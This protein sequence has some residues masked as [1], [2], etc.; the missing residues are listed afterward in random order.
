MRHI[1]LLLACDNISTNEL[2]LFAASAERHNVG[3]YQPRPG[4]TI[5]RDASA[6]R[7]ARA[8]CLD[9][10]RAAPRRRDLG[11]LGIGPFRHP[12]EQQSSGAAE[13]CTGVVDF[14]HFLDATL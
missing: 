6:D 1:Y 8:H 11:R 10:P 4:I 12:L 5:Q 2:N 14:S 3:S 13:L 7:L 9:L